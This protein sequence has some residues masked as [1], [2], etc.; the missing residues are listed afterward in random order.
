MQIL[1][2]I[3]IVDL[4]LYLKK[5]KTLILSD[6]HIGIEEAMNKQGYLIPRFQFKDLIKRLEIILKKTK[7][8]TIII[9]G[10]LK[11]EFGSISDQEW[12]HTLKLIDFLQDKAEVILIKGNHDKILKP[13]AEKR[14]IKIQDFYEIDNIAIFHGHKEIKTDKD[15][16]IIGHYHPAITLTEGIRSEKYK[17]FLKGKYKNKTLIV[18]PSLNLLTEGTDISKEH[19]LSP[20]LKQNLDNFEVYIV[21]DQVYNFGTLKN[22]NKNI[23]KPLFP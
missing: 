4:G 10:D 16:L 20:Y 21:S 22:I 3:E 23:N 1:N 6:I 11:H 19:L 13:I 2:N 17:C 12:K 7:P 9:N 8:K 5:Q 18:M 15:I 14:D